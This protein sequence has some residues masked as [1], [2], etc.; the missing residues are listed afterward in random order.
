LGLRASDLGYYIA[1]PDGETDENEFEAV[2]P[3][4]DEADSFY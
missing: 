2:D 4:L 1:G 3:P